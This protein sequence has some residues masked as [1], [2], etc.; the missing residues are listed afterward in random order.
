MLIDKIACIAVGQCGGN[1]VSEL[2]GLGYNP[3]YVNTSLEDL[4][5]LNT[6]KK[7]KYH[8]KGTNGMSKNRPYAMDCITSGTTAED[9]CYAIYER[10]SMC[11]IVFFFYSLSGGTGGTMGN[12][13]ADQFADLF[14]DKTVNVVTVL[15]NAIED[16]GLLANAI[17]SLK[18]LLEL[19]DQNVITQIHLLDNNTREDKLDINKTFSICFDRFVQ[20]R[21]ISK[22]G[23][24]DENERES[25]LT[26]Y[27]MGV[28][29]EFS[30][31]DFGNGLAKASD[32]TIYAEWIK[33]PKLHG[34]IFNKKQNLNINREVVR[35]VL[36]VATFTHSSEWDYDSNVLVS[37]GMTKNEKIL[38]QLKLSAQ[39]ML[40]KKRKI[41]TESLQQSNEDI[42]FDTSSIIN[43]VS[44]KRNTPSQNN[45][46]V[47]RRRKESSGSSI[48]D[49]Y[50]NMG[51]K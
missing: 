19:H 11:D 25:I 46:P 26:S 31:E 10:Y 42:K 40:E 35:D 2:E 3:Y 27:G 20:F 18:H 21:E 30:D 44:S 50:K 41:E 39:N 8:I 48:I 13:I 14:P 1:F 12:V 49:K 37:V 9:I 34:L 43:N 45:T 47:N 32:K 24:L 23:N 17:E 15:P 7:N 5:T 6:D 22:D 28:I 38:N 51:K 36:G 33:N 4:D 16:V 29:L